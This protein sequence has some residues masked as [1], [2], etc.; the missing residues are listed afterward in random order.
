MTDGEKITKVLNFARN[1]VNDFMATEN[2][3]KKMD[4]E[5]ELYDETEAACEH[6]H[7]CLRTIVMF[8][9]ED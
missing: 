3:M 2:R 8:L 4:D 6:L 9:A 5:E 1:G 7:M